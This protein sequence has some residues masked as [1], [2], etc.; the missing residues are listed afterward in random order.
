MQKGTKTQN[1]FYHN[2]FH[3]SMFLAVF[4]Y[5]STQTDFS[6]EIVCYRW[7]QQIERTEFGG[8]VHVLF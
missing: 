3:K 1:I 5:K 6:F 7:A 8:K 4:G 2:R